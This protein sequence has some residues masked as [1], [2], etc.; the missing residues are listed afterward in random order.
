VAIPMWMRDGVL[1]V[2]VA[3]P[4]RDDLQRELSSAAS[5]PIRLL[6]APRSEVQR[7]IDQSYRALAGVARHV[8]EFELTSAAARSDVAMPTLQQAVDGSAP[9]VQVVNLIVTQ[10]LRDRASDVHIEPMGDQV[11]VRMRID[12]ALH[13]ALSLPSEIGPAIVSRIKVMG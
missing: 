9:V 4:Q 1:E 7:A 2:A 8:R 13:D 10:A 12:G 11:R 5:G 3:D 6:V